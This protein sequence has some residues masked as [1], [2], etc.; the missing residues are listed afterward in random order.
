MEY[1]IEIVDTWNRRITTV[2]ST[3][4]LEVTRGFVT[5][6]VA[7]TGMLPADLIDVGHEY[8]LRVYLADRLEAQAPVR[9][10]DAQ[11]GERKKL[12]LD[13]YVDFHTIIEVAAQRDYDGTNAL[14]TKAYTAKEISEIVKDAIES[15]PGEIHYLVDHDSY[16]DGAQREYNKFVSR[17][18]WMS[19]LPVGSIASGEYV[20]SSRINSSNAYAKDGDTIAGL[21]VDGEAWP[22]LRLM[23][24]DTEELSINTHTI[25]MHPEVASWS[26]EKYA[27]SGYRFKADRAK[28]ALQNLIDT[29]GIECIELN[30]HRNAMGEFDNRVDAYGRYIGLVYGG[31]E[32]F[33]AAMVELGHSGVYLYEDG[34]YNPPEMRLNEY[35][36]YTG[37]NADSVETTEASLSNLD[38]HNGIYEVLTL[39]AY[40]AGGYVWS[41]DQNE[42]VTF[43][44]VAV[45]DR[46]IFYNPK[47]HSISLR[48]DSSNVVN[49]IRVL[50]NPVGGQFEK[51]YTN[52]PSADEFGFRS[53]TLELFSVSQERDADI[54]VPRLLDDVAYPEPCGAITF[55][56]G[57]AAIAP[58]QIVEIRGGEIERVTRRVDGEYGDIFVDRHVFR[59]ARKETLIRNARVETRCYLAPV[60]RSVDDPLRFIVKSQPRASTFFQ[61]R[62]DDEAVGVDMGYHLD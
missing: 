6:D 9:I 17:L 37:P 52:G 60:I 40:A 46:V 27:R 39:L 1:R 51:V 59:V 56:D 36:S 32:C 43:R 50:G 24:I 8:V 57:D 35:Y 25:K 53:H 5:D 23:M 61:F 12:V 38:L 2:Y 54:I 31:G 22:D 18:A 11:W 15:V 13:R 14:L 58:G 26:E 55:L 20:G 29:K 21:V 33:N 34:A 16:P 7:I 3:H 49:T 44:K 19:E 4:L 41:I 30:W 42:A 10:V 28:E 62:L 48:S 45:P 47:R